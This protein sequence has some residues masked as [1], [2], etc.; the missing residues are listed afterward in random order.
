MQK[1]DFSQCLSFQLAADFKRLHGKTQRTSTPFTA[2]TVS[3]TNPH[4]SGIDALCFNS[5]WNTF[6][7]TTSQSLFSLASDYPSPLNEDPRSHHVHQDVSLVSKCSDFDSGFEEGSSV[8]DLTQHSDVSLDSNHKLLQDSH[9]LSASA[10]HP[11]QIKC[12]TSHST[13][14]CSLRSA[15]SKSWDGCMMDLSLPPP[16]WCSST[17]LSFSQPKATATSQ[18]SI[19]ESIKEMLKNFSPVEPDRLIGRKM[20]LET[21]DVVSELHNRSVPALGLVFQYLSPEDLCR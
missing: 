15:K 19:E 21:V 5:H 10:T 12:D 14:T 20:G 7:T 9:R 1:S 17:P 3:V 18:D 2:R 16:S 8:K 11:G 4:D 6:S 13:S